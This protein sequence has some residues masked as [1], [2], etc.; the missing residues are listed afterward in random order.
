MNFCFVGF[1]LARMGGGR[2]KHRNTKYL[3][4]FF[5]FSKGF[6][7]QISDDEALNGCASSSKM[8][9]GGAQKPPTPTPPPP[10]S[11]ARRLF[12]WICHEM[13]G[14]QIRKHQYWTRRRR[15]TLWVDTFNMLIKS[16]AVLN[17]RAWLTVATP[18]P[19]HRH[20]LMHSAEGEREAHLEKHSATSRLHKHSCV[21]QI[22]CRFARDSKLPCLVRAEVH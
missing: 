22:R 7:M 2:K 9:A 3:S 20:H 1:S 8:H 17:C 18:P 21:T 5:F 16:L 19:H 13:W 6:R 14:W 4:R 15:F 12:S 11:L 10:C